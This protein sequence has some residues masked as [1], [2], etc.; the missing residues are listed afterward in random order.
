VEARVN[1]VPITTAD[2]DLEFARAIA[3]AT[4]VPGEEQTR[5]LELQLLSDMIGNRI[6]LQIAADQQLTAT[7]AEVDLRFSEFRSQY[8]EE[9]FNELMEAQGSTVEDVRRDMR[10]G[11]TIDKLINKEITSKIS[12]TQAE[13]QEF[14]DANSQSFNLP[15]SYRVSHVLVT[16]STELTITNSTGDDAETSEEAA[17][18]AQRLLP[19]IQG[20]RDFATVARESSE[21]PSTANVGGDLGFQPLEALAGVDPALADAVS[22]I[23]VGETYPRLVATQFGYHILKL[24]DRDP[25]GQKDLSDP[26][27]E[28]QIRQVIFNRRDQL[29]RAAF[30]ETIR[31][32][33]EVENFLA[34]RILDEA[35]Q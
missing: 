26:R 34:R 33:A 23:R 18:K 21:D 11:L 24:V 28:A 13:I 30:F 7:D 14:F 29:L 22:G 5:D 27:V 19:E 12:V 4:S 25:G 35:G 17:E 8:T 9:R 16:P 1:G 10:E 3:G 20:G 15:E 31:N 32:Q 2:L 6:L